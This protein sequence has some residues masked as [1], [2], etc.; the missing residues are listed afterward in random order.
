MTFVDESFGLPLI[1]SGTLFDNFKSS[2]F[3]SS[4]T[5]MNLNSELTE[6]N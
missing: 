1:G 5:G 3:S 2:Y 6:N 4:L